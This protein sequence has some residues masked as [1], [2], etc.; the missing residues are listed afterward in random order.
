MKYKIFISDFDGTLVRDD[1]TVSSK[2]RAAI[3]EYTEKGG[4]FAVCTGRMTPAILP[5]VRE[6]GLSGPVASFQGAVV[7]DIQTGK[8]LRLC[9]FDDALAYR[10]IAA[11]EE[12]GYHT[13]IYTAEKM[14]CNVDDEALKMYERVCGVKAE[15]VPDLHRFAQKNALKIVKVVVFV[16]KEQR[17]ETEERLKKLFGADCYVTSSAHYLVEVMPVGRNKGEAVAFLS[18]Y[19]GVDRQEIAAIGDMNN[20]IP[21]VSAAGGKFAVANAEERL[22]R[23]A[24]VVPACED[25]GV[26]YALEHYAMEEGD[27]E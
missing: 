1:G 14:Y 2:N 13:H 17:A 11:L 7:T 8:T 23:I 10:V 25:D 15:I 4:V 20:D 6:L 16:E 12:R 5:R 22:K 9:V 21:L 26:A 3:R 24:C 19:Y 18:D 27:H